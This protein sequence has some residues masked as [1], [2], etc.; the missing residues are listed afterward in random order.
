M[1]IRTLGG[2]L[3]FSKLD[4]IIEDSVISIHANPRTATM[5]R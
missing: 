2:L 3:N 4:A 5:S 1:Y